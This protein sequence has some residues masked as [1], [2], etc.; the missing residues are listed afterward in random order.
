SLPEVGRTRNLVL[1][2]LIQTGVDVEV[3]APTQTLGDRICRL[4]RTEERRR[5][6]GADSVM[7]A[8][9]VVGHVT[10]LVSARMVE[11]TVLVEDSRRCQEALRGVGGLGLHLDPSVGPGVG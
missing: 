1:V 6:D 2:A 8:A 5:V 3:D 4:K 9:E 7:D 11:L 10:G